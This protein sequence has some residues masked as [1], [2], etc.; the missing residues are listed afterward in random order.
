MKKTFAGIF[1]L[2]VIVGAFLAVINFETF[3]APKKPS[4]Q[5]KPAQM[6]ENKKEDIIERTDA[7]QDN[8]EPSHSSAPEEVAAAPTVK[9]YQSIIIIRPLIFQERAVEPSPSDTLRPHRETKIMIDQTTPQPTATT[10]QKPMNR[11][12]GLLT[13]TGE[14]EEN[15][16][17]EPHSTQVKTTIPKRTKNHFTSPGRRAKP[18]SRL[19]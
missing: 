14:T 9:S 4:L 2:C 1:V 6:V 17:V 13:D 10:E 11:G 19:P 12:V 3:L 16:L 18:L 8:Q 5:E 15:Q 7:P